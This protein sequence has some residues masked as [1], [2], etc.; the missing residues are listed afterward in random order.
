M[1]T[2]TVRNDT[3]TFTVTVTNV[4]GVSSAL[5]NEI[6]SKFIVSL[7]V[8][9]YIYN[10]HYFIAVDVFVTDQSSILSSNCLTVN[11]SVDCLEDI[12]TGNFSLQLMHAF[13]S[14]RDLP[15]YDY[16]TSMVTLSAHSS[17][18]PVG[19]GTGDF[20]YQATLTYQDMAIDSITNLN[21]TKCSIAELQSFLGPGV[22]YKLSGGVDQAVNASHL[23]TATLSCDSAIQH[24]S[25][26]PQTTCTDGSWSSTEMRSCSSTN[27]SLN[28]SIAD[29]QTF[30]G[31][32][33]SYQ[34]DGVES[35][36]SVSH[37]TTATLS[38]SSAIHDLSGTP[39][40]TC[41]DGSWSS[42]EMRPCSSKDR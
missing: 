34:L 39:Q 10:V 36:G 33:V 21:F 30:L 26:M 2:D 6:Q 17:C 41:I 42:N 7:Q 32:G 15:V 28:C 31:A 11:I 9:L 22:Y 37:L 24:L 8:D 3:Y 4:A 1:L 23:T 20:C 12:T 18:V 35:G 25:G 5:S 14:C 19:S 40:T 16:T 13:G 29:L 27:T 38:C